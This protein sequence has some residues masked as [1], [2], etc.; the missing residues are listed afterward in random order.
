[1]SVTCENYIDGEE[2]MLGIW[3]KQYCILK[4]KIPAKYYGCYMGKEREQ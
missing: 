1:M 3:C 4:E 2:N